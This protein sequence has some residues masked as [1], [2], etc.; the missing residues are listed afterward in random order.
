[1]LDERKPRERDALLR[2]A[3]NSLE[4]EHLVREGEGPQEDEPEPKDGH[5]IEEQA[6]DN[7]RELHLRPAPPRED[8]TEDDPE[9]IR[10]DHGRPEQEQRRPDPH[11]NLID[12]RDVRI[13]RHPEVP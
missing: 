9:D 11:R 10:D 7:R 5:G 3:T 12:D 2:E 1:M 13:E 8:G 4:W 6:H